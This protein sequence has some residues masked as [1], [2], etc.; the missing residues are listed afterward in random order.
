MITDLSATEVHL[1]CI[2][3]FSFD[4]YCST[5]LKVDAAAQQA[6]Q[7][8]QRAASSGVTGQVVAL[9]GMFSMDG[10]N[11]GISTSSV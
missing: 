9:A 6:L 11:V 8:F 2:F 1:H 3:I 5:A 7:D 4:E 10:A